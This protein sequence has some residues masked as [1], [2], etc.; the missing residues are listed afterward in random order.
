MRHKN[1]NYHN[2]RL[3][4]VKRFHHYSHDL[5]DTTTNRLRKHLIPTTTIMPQM[6]KNKFQCDSTTPT[7]HSLQQPTTMSTS[8]GHLT[9]F[10][11]HNIVNSFIQLK[12]NGQMMMNMFLNG[13]HLL[14]SLVRRR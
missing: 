10:Q 5:N 11:N 4:I 2:K 6:I 3:R 9:T 13:Y 12:I 8:E 14:A 1:K 7:T